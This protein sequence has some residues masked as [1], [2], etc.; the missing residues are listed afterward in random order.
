MSIDKLVMAEWYD[1]GNISQSEN[2]VFKN[3]NIFH[4]ST[5]LV[6]SFAHLML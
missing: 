4:S 3:K 5:V 2:I 1:G 6:K